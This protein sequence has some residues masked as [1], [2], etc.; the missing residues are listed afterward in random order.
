MRVAM[1]APIAWRTPPRHYGPWE[2]VVSLLTEGL[3]ARGVDVTLYA[4][5]DSHTAGRLVG[6]CPRGYEEDPDLLPKVWECLHISEVFEHGDD[7]DLIHNH[8]D[9]LPLTYMNLTSTPVLTTIHGF[10]S[11]KILP[12]YQKYNHR[13]HYVAISDADRHPSLTYCATIHHGIDL[14][15]FTFRPEPGRYLLFFGRIHPDKG[16]KEAIEIAQR[17]DMPLIMAG[18]VQ[19]QAYFAQEVA[20]HVDGKGVVYLGS[21]GPEQRDDILGGAYALLHP[22]HFD[23]PFGLSVV[24]AMACGTPVIACHRG[25]MP[26]VIAHGHTGFLVSSVNEAIDVLPDISKLERSACRQRVAAHFSVDRMVEDYRHLYQQIVAEPR[27]RSRKARSK[28]GDH[29]GH[30][31]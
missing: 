5:Q 20:P 14:H 29:H 11:P 1:L 27:I 8:F 23:E 17:V 10:S 26:E 9:Y 4:T 16:A 18:I 21:V 19:D 12:V 24:E 30:I 2:S 22:I 31:S 7:Y 25:S 15:Q 13:A 6:V 3:V 28:V